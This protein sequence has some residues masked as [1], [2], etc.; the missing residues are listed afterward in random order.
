M[1]IHLNIQKLKTASKRDCF[2]GKK[3]TPYNSITSRGRPI[4][5]QEI[6]PLKP[7]FLHAILFILTEWYVNF[8][9][10]IVI[11]IYSPQIPHNHEHGQQVGEYP[12]P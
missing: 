4:L 9:G 2:R 11:S 3:I 5:G 10:R 8:N 1:P 7:V 6:I 12:E